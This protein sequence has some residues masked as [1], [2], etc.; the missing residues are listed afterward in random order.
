MSLLAALDGDASE[1]IWVLGV[2]L[3]LACLAGA[4]VAAWRQLWVACGL[5]LLVA[6]VAGVLLL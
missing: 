1:A 4:G 5:L 6:L 2:V 3:V